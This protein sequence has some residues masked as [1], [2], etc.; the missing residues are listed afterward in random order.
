MA[1]K[2][3]Q[4]AL[5]VVACAVAL[6]L[7]AL[8]VFCAEQDAAGGGPPQAKQKESSPPFAA[9]A[10]D[11]LQAEVI[12]LLLDGKNDEA[13]KL[14]V[15]A[16]KAEKDKTK[17]LDLTYLLAVVEKMSD[18]ND[19]AVKHLREVATNQ[20]PATTPDAHFRRALLLR[21]LGD[22][23]YLER[24]YK[25]ALS[26]YNDALAE[27]AG[28]PKE[29]PVTANIIESM[30]GALL[31]EKRLGEAET[32]AKRLV[33]SSAERAKSGRFEDI[34]E[35][36]WSQLQLLGIYRTTG[37]DA[38]RLKQREVV[39]KLF[40]QLNARRSELDVEGSVEQIDDMQK[41]F[42]SQYI[43]RF[44]PTSAAEYMWLANE[45]KMRSM[46]LI[47][48]SPKSGAGKCV[49][50]CVHGLGLENRAFTVFGRAM[51]DRGHIVYAMDVR[52]F[53]AW[54]AAP[55]REEVSFNDTLEDIGGIIGLLKE[56]H[57][58]LPLYLLG[59]SMGG[60]IVLQ[61]GA[62]YEGIIDGVISSVPSPERY[63]GRRMAV[64]TAVHFLKGPN[65]AF[66]IGSMVADKATSRAD[67]QKLWA[68]D[69]KAKMNMSPK[70]LL[71]FDVFMRTTKRQCEQ[72]KSTPV[73]V[74]QGLKD[75]LVKPQ[76]TYDLFDAVTCDDKDMF[77]VGTSEH[78][79]FENDRP[80]EI[81]LNTLNNW[82]NDH[83]SKKNAAA[84]ATD[85]GIN[86][87]LPNSN[88]GIKLNR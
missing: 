46:P 68:A 6:S 27:C 11:N 56:R 3:L 58:G 32:Y 66:N 51:A 43:N 55:G 19:S 17:H 23:Y 34:G 1:I 83:V 76:G 35:L 26:S 16:L 73:F 14:L 78:L 72:I 70:E 87:G 45:F 62:R 53:G 10:I 28:L 25:Q 69:A 5:D 7:S 42:Q 52:G 33:V 15:D 77:I 82:L 85:N 60:A 4:V 13:Q 67:L 65:K 36:F 21:R 44:K 59:E 47:S 64:R 63:Q 86:A 30:M 22:C 81:V 57:P 37:Q 9:F 18:D 12:Q 40:D 41:N 71:K 2:R 24:D 61:S 79:I 84:D 48:W 39:A 8:P 54:Q 74:L 31:H 75:R 49:V 88:K 29:S 80:S 50:L 20:P 38:E